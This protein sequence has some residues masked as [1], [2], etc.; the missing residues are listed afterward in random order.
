M[1]ARI[2]TKLGT[3]AIATL[4]ALAIAEVGASA[5]DGGA[6]PYLRL[7]VNDSRFGV[8]LRPNA[9]ARVRSYLG[10]VTSVQTNAL[11]FRGRDW[12][13]APAGARAP[14]RGRVLLLGDSQMLGL[15]VPFE[16]T[17]AAR[18]E[19]RGFEVLDAAV[20]TWGPIEHVRALAELAPVFRPEHVVF[21]GNVANDWVESN[22]PNAERTAAEDGW[23]VRR[24][25]DFREPRAFP[26][27]DL[28]FGSHLVYAIRVVQHRAASAAPQPRATAVRTLVDHL[29]ELTRPRPGSPWRSPL[30]RHLAA[31]AAI[32]A[33]Y[34]CEVTA[35]SLPLDVQVHPAEW[36]K[37]GEVARDVDGLGAL[38]RAF[39]DDAR[40]LGIASVD[41][42]P[43]LRAASPGA[44][45]ADDPHLG[46]K[47][48]RAVARAIAESI[49][50]RSSHGGGR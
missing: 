29:D 25:R 20:P 4:L 45:L 14:V 35:A 28:L 7:F 13:P 9:E 16:L 36:A 41:L 21:V 46:P 18:L 34:G 27:R 31:A 39:L 17:T 42:A 15:H 26:G 30:G 22:V 24:S 49:S 8:R 44:Y 10:R 32:C 50:S 37:Y 23:A 19:G 43:A 40:S 48:H 12:R 5:L 6:F 38:S 3:A 11:G 33:R 2:A 47:G 1:G